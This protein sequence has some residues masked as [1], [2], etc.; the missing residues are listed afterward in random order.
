MA[1]STPCQPCDTALELAAQGEK[2]KCPKCQCEKDITDFI[3]KRTSGYKTENQKAQ[4]IC[5]LCKNALDKNKYRT[6]RKDPQL[7]RDRGGPGL[8]Y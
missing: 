6:E 7:L 1:K 2:K 5:K 4:L 3:E 8:R